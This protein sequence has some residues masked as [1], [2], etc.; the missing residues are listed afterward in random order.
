MVQIGKY[1][2]EQNEKFEFIQSIYF[3]NTRT[4]ITNHKMVAIDS[5]L[6]YALGRLEDLVSIY[7][8]LVYANASKQ[9]QMYV[10][11]KINNQVGRIAKLMVRYQLS[12]V[13]IHDLLTGAMSECPDL[14]DLGMQQY[15]D[16]MYC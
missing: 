16:Y 2:S 14:F 13:I 8:K 1:H 7:L 10:Y 11:T 6:N 9:E 5:P 4:R 3:I 15:F 12:D